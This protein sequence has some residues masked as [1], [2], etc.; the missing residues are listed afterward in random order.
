MSLSA[1]DVMHSFNARKLSAN[2]LFDNVSMFWYPPVHPVSLFNFRDSVSSVVFEWA[3]PF[4]E[5]KPNCMLPDDR[6]STTK[7]SSNI[8]A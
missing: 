5:S 4:S 3:F 1:V 6:W 2:V 8:D 7:L